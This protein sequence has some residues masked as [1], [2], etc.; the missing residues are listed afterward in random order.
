MGDWLQVIE[1]L[2]GGLSAAVICGLAYAVWAE[3]KRANEAYDKLL[4]AYRD[5]MQATS[6]NTR[7]LEAAIRSVKG[8][9]P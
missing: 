9:R 6:E 8:D 3:R 7:V 5:T 1:A 4:D 2:G